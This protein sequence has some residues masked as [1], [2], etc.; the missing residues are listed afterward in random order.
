MPNADKLLTAA[1]VAAMIPVHVET[2]R[3]WAREGRLPVVELPS[4]RKR[5]RASDVAVLLG[6]GAA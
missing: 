3:R 5:Y 6:R 1:Q 4:G 2:V